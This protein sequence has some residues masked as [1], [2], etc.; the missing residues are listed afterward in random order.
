MPHKKAR[1]P[2][3]AHRLLRSAGLKARKGLGQNFLIDNSIRDA[4]LDAAALSSA[5]TVIEIGPGLGML[6]GELVKRVG[7]V[8]AVEL[9]NA[10]AD[11]I[12]QKLKTAANLEVISSDILKLGLAGVLKGEKNYKVV[13]NIPYYITSPILH[14]FLHAAARPS[15]MVIMLQKEVALAVTSPPGKL[16]FLAV[17]MRIFS[18]PEIVCNVPAA[19]FYPVPAVDSAVVRF[20]MLERPAVEADN[21]DKFLEF[22]HC[23]F[24]APRKKL[25]N[26]L[27][28]GLKINPEISGKILLKAGIDALRRPGT[29]SPQEWYHLYR[30]KEGNV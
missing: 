9:D 2:D 23:G 5:D 15:L 22:V 8:I 16:N 30:V 27:A 19:S 3:Q 14:L 20:T 11:R 13:A 10:L 17:S 24:S 18:R 28:L 25:R 21:L 29:L 6:T 26:S 4:I 1:H 7:R 12:R